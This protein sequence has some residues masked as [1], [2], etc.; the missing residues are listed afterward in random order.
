MHAHG[1]VC[2]YQYSLAWFV[3][4]FQDT[5]AKAER[6]RDLA[7]RI[8]SLVA[9]FQYSLFVQVR[10]AWLPETLQMGLP[11]LCLVC[12]RLRY[13]APARPGVQQPC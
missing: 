2:R 7:R 6:A 10:C 8:D 3:G 13:C 11:C 5:L 9:H 1:A 4:L 12:A